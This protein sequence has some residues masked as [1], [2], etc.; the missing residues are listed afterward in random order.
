MRKERIDELIAVYRDGLLND[1]IPFWLKYGLDNEHGG[2]I[3]SVDRD[4]TV[5]DTDK[6]MWQQGRFAW[7]MAN[8]YDARGYFYYQK[9]RLYTKRFNLMRWA[10]G[11]MCRALAQRLR[12]SDED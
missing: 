12:F 4:G 6:N 11:W 1:T 10:N 9:T 7:T 3:T 8:L 2:I 5:I